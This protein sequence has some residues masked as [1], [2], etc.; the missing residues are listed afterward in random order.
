MVQECSSVVIPIV[1]LNS[2][3]VSQTGVCITV[4]RLASW[5]CVT[6]IPGP[7]R[8]PWVTR[9]TRWALATCPSF[10]WQTRRSGWSSRPLSPNPWSPPFSLLSCQTPLARLPILAVSTRKAWPP[11][12]TLL[13]LRTW[14]A[15]PTR[16]S[17]W[18][19]HC[20]D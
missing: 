20:S 4:S 19:R 2:H 12:W 13:S 18:S 14:G 9:S 10:T 16:L 7:P 5:S 15:S 6:W 11:G 3:V 1:L 8:C 17:R